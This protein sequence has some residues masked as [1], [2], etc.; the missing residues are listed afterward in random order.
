MPTFKVN[1]HRID[2]YKVYRFRVLWDG[3]VV[4]G[5]SRISALRQ[6]TEVI[7]W[8][9]GSEPNRPH[10]TPSMTTYEPITLERGVTHDIEFEKWADQ[11]S[12]SVGDDDISLKGFRK[13][14]TIELMNEA[15][16]VAKSYRVLR[17]WP[18]HYQAL[19]DLD[20]TSNA[21][22]IER[23]VLQHEGFIRDEAVSEPAET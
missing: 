22:A 9:E 12:N 23:I 15:G 5:I 17:A 20:A 8:R 21:I 11:V 14:I 3:R 18:S 13:D 10:L 2:P 7:A 6:M 4:A 1:P 19:P 16:Q